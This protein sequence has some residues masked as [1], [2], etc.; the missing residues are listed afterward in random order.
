MQTHFALY[1][2]PGM[3]P[4]PE[5]IEATT[6]FYW[7][8]LATLAIAFVLLLL[9]ALTKRRWKLFLGFLIFVAA[10]TGLNMAWG[11]HGRALLHEAEIQQTAKVKKQLSEGFKSNGVYPTQ[12]KDGTP[13]KL[14]YELEIKDY[15]GKVTF[16][17]EK[18][19]HIIF[20]FEAEI[21]PESGN[22]RTTFR[23][24][25]AKWTLLLSEDEWLT[26]L[27]QLPWYVIRGSDE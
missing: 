12:H 13:C 10:L 16:Y 14:P 26:A 23:G 8:C 24:K 18:D 25:D 20:W 19:G 4:R 11:A 27:P 5:V 15:V 1:F 21:R 9:R 17:D 7:F 3:E 22:I 6:N 2:P